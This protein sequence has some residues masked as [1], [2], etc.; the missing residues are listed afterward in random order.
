MKCPNPKCL[1]E[2]EDFLTSE[3]K[4]E[5]GCPKC[6]CG[7]DPSHT[8]H[9]GDFSIWATNYVRRGKMMVLREALPPLD[10]ESWP[11][12][13]KEKYGSLTDFPWRQV[14]GDGWKDA[15]EDIEKSMRRCPHCGGDL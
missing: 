8:H 2:G 15:K 12:L 1:H 11:S 9:M 7:F 3:G 14:Y 5:V 6:G 13:W 4:A 10:S